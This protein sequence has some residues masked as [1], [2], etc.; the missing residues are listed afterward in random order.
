M[1]KGPLE[2]TRSLLPLGLSV[3][4]PKVYKVWLWCL[5][6]Q[7]LPMFLVRR[8]QYQFSRPKAINTS[9]GLTYY[10]LPWDERARERISSQFS[11]DLSMRV[12]LSLI[13]KSDFV[14]DVGVNCGEFYLPLIIKANGMPEKPTFWGFEP[15]SKLNECVQLSLKA[16]KLYNDNVKLWNLGLG[17]TEERA[18][19]HID[20]F[21]SGFSSVDD[22]PLTVRRGGLTYD[23]PI[24]I[25][26]LD[27]LITENHISL[28]QAFL[29][30][31]DT[32]GLDFDVLRGAYNLL[33]KG[34]KLFVIFEFDIDKMENLK[35]TSPEF[36]DFL[37]TQFNVYGISHKHNRI[38]PFQKD[39][40]YKQL[41]DFSTDEDSGNVILMRGYSDEAL[42]SNK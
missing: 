19:F 36:L 31:I 40:I 3:R 14:I 35:Q 22:N 15:N 26:T 18:I 6:V 13:D 34:A 39:N 4:F 38:F 10:V 20:V 32:E 29:I 2:Y 7:W 21:N 42:I 30:K 1:K 5:R 33:N 11:P 23:L 24:K 28:D 27:T 41:I 25:Q 9:D 17:F 12:F 37:V 16:N 8:Y